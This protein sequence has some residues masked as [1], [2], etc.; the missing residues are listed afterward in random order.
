MDDRDF[1]IL[2]TLYT[3]KNITKTGQ[4]LFISQPTMTARLQK[5]EE[6]FGVKIVYRGN[7][8]V[9]FT[10]QGEYLA[11]FASE[12]LANIRN[13][14]EQVLNMNSK[15]MGTLRIGASRFFAK[16][17][18]PAILKLFKVQY[19]DVEFNADVVWSGEVLNLVNSQE[20]HVGFIRGDYNWPGQKHLLFDESIVVASKEKID[21][22]HLPYLSR[23][24]YKTNQYMK[25]TVDSWWREHYSLPPKISMNV[26]TVDTCKEMVLNGLGY[27]IMPGMI[28][29]D[30]DTIYQI[31]LVD[32][33]GG[34]PLIR[35]TWMIYQDELLELGIVKAFINFVKNLDFQ[36]I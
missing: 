26:D 9:H 4:I 22:A 16:Y 31:R 17:K 28:L 27:A 23:I 5:I 19:P 21:L 24:N 18:L 14:K 32:K 3:Q 25:N 6:E 7:K 29:K 1:L 13:A 2:E 15:V 30:I 20:V 8:G 34:M 12:T 35:K 10:P 11:R 33:S 36:K